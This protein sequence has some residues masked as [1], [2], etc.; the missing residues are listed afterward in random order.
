MFL[1]N[2]VLF[3]SSSQFL[4]TFSLTMTFINLK[5]NLKSKVKFLIILVILRVESTKANQHELTRTI[6][7]NTNE[8]TQQQAA[9]GVIRR[10]IGDKADDVA[11]K[12]NFNLP[13]NYFKVSVSIYF[14]P[15]LRVEKCMNKLSTV[16]KCRCS[17]RYLDP[18][19]K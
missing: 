5:I 1:I 10:L 17:F 12:I 13:G 7:P 9:L 8:D 4:S 15:Q 6:R 14:P 11:I 16:M 18:Q 2:F 3:C 19:N